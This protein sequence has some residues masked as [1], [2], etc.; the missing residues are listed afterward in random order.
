M[1][2]QRSKV[3]SKKYLNIFFFTARIVTN[4]NPACD[5]RTLSALASNA[6]ALILLTA[7]QADL[8]R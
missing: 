8:F 4:N 7:A 6:L 2:Y 3:Q 1:N 5:F